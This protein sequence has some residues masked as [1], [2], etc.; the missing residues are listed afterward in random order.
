MIQN[1]TSNACGTL[2]SGT[3]YTFTVLF[4]KLIL[5]RCALSIRSHSRPVICRF[6]LDFSLQDGSPHKLVYS[7]KQDLS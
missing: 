3:D 5:F 6:V 1:F 2:Y 4:M 7:T